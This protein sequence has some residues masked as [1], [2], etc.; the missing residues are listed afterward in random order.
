MILQSVNY[1][2][3]HKDVINTTINGDATFLDADILIINPGSFSHLWST[4]LKHKADGTPLLYSSSGSDRIRAMFKARQKEIET[5]LNNGKILIVFVSPVTGFSGEIGDISQYAPVYNYD[6]LPELSEVLVKSLKPGKGTGDNLKLRHP[7]NMFVPY[8]K[9]FND[10]L[11]YSAYLDISSEL[12][13]INFITNRSD[14]PVGFVVKQN[15]GVIAFLPPPVYRKQNDKLVGVI[16]NCCKNFFV[17]TEITPPPD[18]INDFKLKGEAEYD[19]KISEL[20]KKINKITEEKETTE[21]EKCELVEF[22]ALLY[23]QGPV[24]E[25]AVLRSFRLF[26]FTAD[27]RKMDDLEHDIVFSSAE[28]RGIAEV[29]GKDNDA[30]HVSKFDQLNRAVDEDFDLKGDYPAGVLIGNHYRFSR[31]SNRKEAFSE[32]V[33][34]VAKKK[35]F[36]LLTTHE[37]YKAVD[38]L[39]NNPNDESF[40]ESCR[41]KILTTAGTSISLMP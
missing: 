11:Q 28:G 27:N 22:K 41:R 32:K 21:K 39:L 8:Y 38:Y 36:G 13:E 17:N 2:I 12:D 26:G 30:I 34:I 7:K 25:K 9:A 3:Q 6:F 31:P 40:K 23:E 20:Q 5:L 24:L 18:W 16:L 4:N 35:N 10:E 15:N 19:L 14:K 1:E 29:E 33:H 37:I